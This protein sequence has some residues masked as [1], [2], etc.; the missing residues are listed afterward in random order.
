MIPQIDDSRIFNAI[1][2]SG[3]ES[4]VAIEQGSAL[5][6]A[7]AAQCV[8]TDLKY[9][10][11]GLEVGW[12]I[13][14]DPR[15]FVVGAVDKL[16]VERTSITERNTRT[17]PKSVDEYLE[18]E[19]SVPSA[20]GF[21]T[22]VVES[23]PFVFERK[24]TS[25]S[26]TW[27]AEKWF[28]DLRKG[29]QVAIY[30]A[31]LKWGTFIYRDDS[32]GRCTEEV[33][34]VESPRVLA[35]AITKTKPPMVWPT[36]EGAWIDFTEA[37]L[38]ATMAAFRNTAAA[39][40]AQRSTGVVPW[41]LPGFHCTLTFGFTKRPCSAWRTCHETLEY[42]VGDP[43]YTPVGLS[44]GSA[45]VV[46]HLVRT[47]RIPVDG[48]ADVVILSASSSKSYQQCPELWRQESLGA[49][50]QES[51]EAMDIGTVLHCG[52]AEVDRILKEAGF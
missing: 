16:A 37:R 12:F 40:R 49:T 35:R 29:S 36:P 48:F 41:Q 4:A 43:T 5:V 14:L 15:T 8:E 46:D 26:K 52:M 3:V 44:P 20:P 45:S 51:N 18:Q 27:T 32:L 21:S 23:D 33:Y 13:A 39:I 28:E 10:T 6:D 30:A 47:G 11:L 17:V 19:K 9:R 7:W 24:T 31:A 38:N 22:T 25:A 1:L 50:E 42:P 2:A 34:K